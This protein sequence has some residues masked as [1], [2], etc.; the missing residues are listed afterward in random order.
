[1]SYNEPSPPGNTIWRNS[2]VVLLSLFV[3]ASTLPGLSL[4]WNSEG[5]SYGPQGSLG[6]ITDYDG[7]VKAVHPGSPA[8]AEGIQPGDRVDLRRTS[9][10]DRPFV[11]P[12]EARMRAGTFVTL[13]VI[14][15]KL[16]RQ[17]TLVAPAAD[18]PPI[19]KINI[20][21]RTL[22]VL[23]FV[24]VGGLLVVLRPSAMTWGF[25]FYCLGF[26][27]GIALGGLSRFPSAP[28]HAAYILFTDLLTAAG[29]VGILVFSLRFLCNTTSRWRLSLEQAT[30]YLFGLFVFLVAYPDLANLIL[31]YPAEAVQRVMLTLQ[32]ATF[33]LSIFAALD[34]YLHGRRDDQPRIQWVV[35]GLC[36]GIAGTYLGSV[37]LFSS[38][39]PFNPPRW[40]QS[41]LL[42]LN[43]ILPISVAY[44]VI[45]HRVLEVSFV[46]SRALIYAVLTFVVLCL[47]AFIDWFVGRELEQVRLASYVEI[48]LAIGLSFWLN[49]L[50]KRVE[51]VVATVF[52]RKRGQAMQRIERAAQ[53][54]H[55]AEKVSTIYDYVVREPVEA[56]S[57]S[58]SALFLPVDGGGYRRVAAIGW[59]SSNA[60]V[61]EHDDPLALEL[62]AE[63]EP[64][65]VAQ[66]GW[67]HADLPA[68]EAAPIL[69]IPMV[70]RRE[71]L[72]IA[73]YGA[74]ANGADIDPDEVRDLYQLARAAQ[75]TYDHLRVLELEAQLQ[76]LQARIASLQSATG[77][78]T[79]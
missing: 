46:V 60:W 7:V 38:E 12:A 15:G 5:T 45:R 28:S 26:S 35:V 22:A 11:A 75:A 79:G 73:L 4:L 27:P 6:F 53:A 48:G 29:T 31:G 63:C 13:W 55:H 24:V 49:S 71:L 68:R 32:G 51:T 8:S 16:E 47:F 59:S 69:A 56:L 42:T 54:V 67:K 62:A 19:S 36:V 30:P 20:L 2:I 44:A 40:L 39:L 33:A 41:A 9:F 37:L 65:R 52:F 21:A 10:D 1:M 61:I 78:L 43:V 50:E 74:H 72:G 18:Y 23:I 58:S 66:I 70:A 64:V 14:H 3:I 34:T 25:F 77:E 17:V 57:L 76:Q